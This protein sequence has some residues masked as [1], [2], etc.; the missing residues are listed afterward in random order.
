[1]IPLKKLS[2]LFIFAVLFILFNIL[3]PKANADNTSSVILDV[4]VSERDCKPEQ[5]GLFHQCNVPNKTL[6]AD[7]ASD[8]QS[9]FIQSLNFKNS[10]STFFNCRSTRNIPAGFNINGQTVDI[11]M[12]VGTTPRIFTTSI[13]SS[14]A[15]YTFFVKI[16]SPAREVFPGCEFSVLSNITT[17]E[18]EPIKEY[19]NLTLRQI[20]SK[21]DE[22]KEIDEASTLPAK[23]I[24]LVRLSGSLE[25]KKTD[26][27]LELENLKSELSILQSKSSLTDFEST[28][29][30]ALPGLIYVTEIKIKDFDLLIQDVEAALPNTSKC[31][32]DN[33]AD[34]TFCLDKVT[35]V[36]ESLNISISEDI[37][38]TEEVLQFLDAEFLRLKNIENQI[39]AQ[40]KELA[41]K[42]STITASSI[43]ICP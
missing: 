36:R 13:P 7:H 15:T 41:C 39:S 25:A 6:E 26:R 28:R 11:L 40:I 20:K 4:F 42:I 5:F 17:P 24:V 19:T 33:P 8:T 38:L 21:K 29:L 2:I 31:I 9:T 32:A 1:M 37:N 14:G 3:T 34:R 16:D 35:K 23:W 27:E 12:Q 22:I 43:N 30:A 10:I 18:L